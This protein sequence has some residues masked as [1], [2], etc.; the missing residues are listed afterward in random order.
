MRDSGTALNCELRE[1]FENFA[2]A[3]GRDL[4]TLIGI[5]PRVAQSDDREILDVWRCE[6]SLNCKKMGQFENFASA[7]GRE[8]AGLTSISPW[9]ALSEGEWLDR[10]PP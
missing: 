5:S 10:S 4:T 8:L 7:S 3:S 2:S 9:E 6:H 1:Q